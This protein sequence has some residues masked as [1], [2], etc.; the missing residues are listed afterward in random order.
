MAILTG[1]CRFG[2]WYVHVTWQD[3]LV[4]RVRFARTGL[5]GPVPDEVVRYCAGRP[6]D[7][8]SFR[9]IATEGDSTFARIYRAVR[10]VPRGE[11]VTYGEIAR[12]VGTAP[13]AV[14]SAMAKNPTPLVVPCHRVVAKTGLGGFSP[15]VTIKEALLAM[16][17]RE[18]V[19]GVNR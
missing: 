4:Y 13:R 12:R 16:E 5:P 7:L 2:L 17:R 6:A 14:G 1:S 3:D 15:D 8:S 19:G 9:S 11:T 18:R 10:A